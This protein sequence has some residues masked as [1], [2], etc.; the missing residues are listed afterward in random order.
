MYKKILLIKIFILTLLTT[1][2]SFLSN[3]II[4]TKPEFEDYSSRRK[5]VGNSNINYQQKTNQNYY[6]SLPSSQ[7]NDQDNNN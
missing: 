3:N 5:P 7:D 2:C 4:F 6:N 1:G